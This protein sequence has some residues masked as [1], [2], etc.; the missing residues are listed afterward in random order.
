MSIGFDRQGTYIMK[1]RVCFTPKGSAKALD[2][3]VRTVHLHDTYDNFVV[4]IN[5]APAFRSATSHV[6]YSAKCC[7]LRM[8][9]L[10]RDG[11]SIH[12]TTKDCNEN[13]SGYP[14]LHL[15]RLQW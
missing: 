14:K 1:V 10:I 12:H 4:I 3:V 8:A 15:P 2:R 6:S 7:S 13:S 11:G 5:Y 9:R